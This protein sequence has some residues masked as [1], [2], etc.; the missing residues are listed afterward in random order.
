MRLLNSYEQFS[1]VSRSPTTFSYTNLYLGTTFESHSKLRRKLVTKLL[2]FIGE[3][4]IVDKKANECLVFLISEV[5][6]LE[7]FLLIFF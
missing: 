2:S 5:T 7:N 4:V 3:G 6:A 1:M